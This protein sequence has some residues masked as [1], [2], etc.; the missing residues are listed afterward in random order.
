MHFHI[1][2]D[3]RFLRGVDH[4]FGFGQGRVQN[5]PIAGLMNFAGAMVRNAGRGHQITRQ[6]NVHGPLVTQG[7]VQHAV[8]FL[9]S[10]LWIAQHRRSHGELLEHFFL[11]VELADLMMEQRIFFTL[12][13][14]RCAADNDNR[15]FFSEGFSGG[16]GNFQS[17]D[18]VGDTDG[19]ETAHARVSIR[20]ETRALLIA[21]VDDLEFAPLE[22]MIE[23]K[24]VIA[25][26]AEYVPHPV[27]VK[28]LDQILTDA[29]RVL[30]ALTRC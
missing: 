12:L 3:H 13:D 21:R 20:R 23:A 26:Y 8:D 30:H 15:R 9:Q 5:A 17:A 24:H 25:R 28:P 2:D 10:G 11:R 14:S 7:G 1:S 16:V 6:L 4:G 22:Q 29:D 19:A 27:R 18:A